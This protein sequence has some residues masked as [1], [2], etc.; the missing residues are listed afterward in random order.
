MF[1]QYPRSLSILVTY[2]VAKTLVLLA[3]HDEIERY[4]YPELASTQRLDLRTRVKICGITTPQDAISAVNS[5]TDAIGLVFY[6]PSPRNVS[7]ERAV[8]IRKHVPPF[9]SVVGV[10][11]NIESGL[12]NDI[13][14]AVNLDYIQYCGD[15]SPSRCVQGPR[16]YIK[17]VAMRDDVDISQKQREFESAQA[18]LLDTFVEGEYGGSGLT[19]DWNNVRSLSNKPII[20]SGGLN[21]ANVAHAIRVVRPYAVDVSTGVERE[22]GLKDAN[23][24][25]EFVYC[26]RKTDVELDAD[27]SEKPNRA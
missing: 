4:F 7:V 12:L 23:K 16:P 20:L 18:L 9:V 2:S 21:V 26:V 25:S 27:G 24:I 15:E 10:V 13:V 8:E 14:A 1:T 11:V 5:G 22:K 17:S 3:Y 19:F 6:E